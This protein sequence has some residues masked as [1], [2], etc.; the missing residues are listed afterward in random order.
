MP[1]APDLGAWR[2]ALAIWRERLVGQSDLTTR[3][4]GLATAKR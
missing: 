1:R 2:Q 4:V 3:L